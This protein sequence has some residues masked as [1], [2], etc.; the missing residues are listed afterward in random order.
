MSK[1]VYSKIIAMRLKEARIL[2]GF[3]QTEIQTALGIP[4]TSLS[5]YENGRMC[6]T[7]ETLG[8]LAVFYGVSIDWLF[9]LGTSGNNSLQE[10]MK[11]SKEA[12]RRA[13]FERKLEEHTKRIAAAS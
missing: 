13:R 6:P 9:G 8:A 5:H 11:I 2:T 3:T 10:E 7:L 12:E 4:K 1:G